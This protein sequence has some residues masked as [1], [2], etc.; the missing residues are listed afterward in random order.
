MLI[1]VAIGRSRR[2]KTWINKKMN[3]SDLVKKF[4][5]THRTTETYKQYCN[6][7]KERQAEIKDIGG[8]VGG[9]LTGGK[10]TPVTNVE[11]RQLITL[12]IDLGHKDIWTDFIM[13]FDCEA[14]VYSTHKHSP[15]NPR[16][17]LIIP[18]DRPVGIDEYE[19]ISRK[20]ADMIGI[21]Y[22]D[23]TTFQP[24]RLMYW[25][26]TSSDGE[27]YFEHQTGTWL[28]AD[29]IL[30]TYHNWKDISSWPMP[31]SEHSVIK[32]DLKKQG[33]P[34][35]K[36]GLIGAFCRA[37][38]VLEAIE[39]FIP[40]EYTD[41]GEDRLTYTGGSAAAGA[42]LYNNGSFLYSHHSTD[43]A[44]GRLVNAFDLVRIHKFGELDTDPTL[45][46]N[47]LP[48]FKKMNEY[49][50]SMAPVIKEIGVF[51]EPLPD[52]DEDE[53]ED[54]DAW[55]GK[56]RVNKA[57][58]YD[59]TINNIVLIISNDENLKG[60]IKF[61]S[62]ESNIFL[63]ENTVW[64]SKVT[65]PRPFIDADDAGLR[66]YIE[67]VYKIF[68]TSKMID[69]VNIVARRNRFHPVQ[70]FICREKWDGISR[71]ETLLPHYMG[72]EDSPYVRA[73]TRKALV[74]SVARVYNPGVKFD[75]MPVLVGSQGI[76]KSTFI[77]MLGS[78]W[79]S[80]SFTTVQGKEAYEQLQGAWLIEIA[81]LSGFKKA[82]I[83]TVKH[84]ISK[85]SDRFRVA[86]G[87]RIE[88]FPRQCVFWG[89]TNELS[90]LKDY[91]GGRRFWPI[92]VTGEGKEPITA[93]PV[94]QI[95][96]EAKH[97]YDMEESLYLEIKEI[98]NEAKEKQKDHYEQDE[99][100]GLIEKY[101]NTLLPIGWD[102]MQRFERKSWLSALD[103]ALEAEGVIERERVCVAEIWCE[104]LGNDFKDMNSANTKFIHQ[105]LANINGWE[106]GKTDKLFPIYG[107]Q[108]TYVR[109]NVEELV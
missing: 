97:Y 17:R 105:I 25:P 106:K 12:D 15:D 34:A 33:E 78:D 16:L 19:A 57:G 88:T 107:R 14:L 68:H 92:T 66:H 22:F 30:A 21:N 42:I 95:W 26:S 87:V 73:V 32:S 41:A 98:E 53:D 104:V 8:F 63:M 69:A 99:R 71:I 40:E 91:T 81:E 76:R 50:S 39:E 56:L 47:Q 84:F 3:W 48:S 23:P 80:D 45:P 54:P 10:R 101:L 18:L 60:K 90:F 13:L 64:D 44:S 108:R 7:S 2:Q 4:S 83:E 52:E 61:N 79:F 9:F 67:R 82:E 58:D 38:T 5:T 35:E 46:I 85:S 43:P 74:A 94:G 1:D 86:Y 109:I 31:D 28:S 20:I 93:M 96:A 62:F 102:K 49:V 27:Y 77:K 65:S 37:Y 36:P 70:E 100:T 89:S 55:R 51:D 11:H 29:D 75:Y 103:D 72:A 24:Q 6:A 59:P